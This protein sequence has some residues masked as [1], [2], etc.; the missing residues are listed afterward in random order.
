MD[1]A[2]TLRAKKARGLEA[3]AHDATGS[4]G[5]YSNTTRYTL[6][7]FSLPGRSAGAGTRARRAAHRPGTTAPG[8]ARA[9][10]ARA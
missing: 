10:A 6:N 8:A 9:R 5:A 7:V 2:S 4:A 3:A 1:D